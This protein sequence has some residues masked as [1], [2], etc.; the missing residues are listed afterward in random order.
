MQWL[1]RRS[2]PLAACLWEWNG[3]PLNVTAIAR[4]MEVT[5]P[6]ARARLR[7]LESEGMIILLPCLGRGRPLIYLRHSFAGYWVHTIIRQILEISPE[8]TFSWWKTG[9][10]RQIDLIARFEG[11]C[12]GIQISANDQRNSAWWPLL[13]ARRRGLIQRGY[14][15][16]AQTRAFTIRRDLFGLPLSGFAENLDAWIRC[17][18]E[19]LRQNN[20]RAFR[21]F[22]AG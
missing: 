14:F 1:C 2:P 20:V 16:H 8:A 10:V 22:S 3:R 18:F 5:R 6:T 9:R 17:P 4:R 12:F 7:K 11:R 13:I 15:L 19:A 21:A